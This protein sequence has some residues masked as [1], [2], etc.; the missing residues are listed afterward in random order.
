MIDNSEENGVS[1]L[2]KYILKVRNNNRI[3]FCCVRNHK[4]GFLKLPLRRFQPL[5]SLLFVIHT[6]TVRVV[7]KLYFSSDF[8][9]IP[10][11]QTGIPGKLILGDVHYINLGCDT[12]YHK[13]FT[14]ILLVPAHKYLYITLTTFHLFSTHFSPINIASVNIF[15]PILTTTLN[16]LHVYLFMNF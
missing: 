11:E 5:S 3:Q 2:T 9:I 7:R 14:F 13:F 15:S 6:V 4:S 12:G 10:F 16:K 8:Y 1:W